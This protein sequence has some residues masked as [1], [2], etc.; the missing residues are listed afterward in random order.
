VAISTLRSSREQ[1]AVDVDKAIHYS[2][3]KVDLSQPISD[4]DVVHVISAD[5]PVLEQSDPSL[6]GVSRLTEALELE[7]LRW[8]HAIGSDIFGRWPAE[9]SCA[10]SGISDRKAL[11]I[12]ER[13]GQEAVFRITVDRQDVLFVKGGALEVLQAQLGEYRSRMRERLSD[14]LQR[15]LGISVAASGTLS[16]LHGWRLCGDPMAFGEIGEQSKFRIV[17]ALNDGTPL[18]KPL[19]ALIDLESRTVRRLAVPRKR[20]ESGTLEALVGSRIHLDRCAWADELRAKTAT[21]YS[22]YVWHSNSPFP[23]APAGAECVYVGVT[24]KSV[25]ERIAEHRGEPPAKSAK[26]VREYDGLLNHSLMPSVC[27][28]T[29]PTAKAFEEWWANLLGYRGYFVKGGH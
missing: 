22:I 1:P 13:F 20:N 2:I 15:T 28:P 5:N 24:G 7:G 4:G 23:N 19:V 16:V 27:L 6:V 18:D 9:A 14:F 8:S 10:V 11:Q 12:A 29:S 21:R 3:A 25:E 26:W 17:R